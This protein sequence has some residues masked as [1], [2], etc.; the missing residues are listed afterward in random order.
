MFSRNS[1]IVVIMF[2]LV[3]QSL[4]QAGKITHLTH[5]LKLPVDWEGDMPEIDFVAESAGNNEWLLRVG[6]TNFEFT[7]KNTG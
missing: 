6:V 7:P 5:E 3:G 4:G 1:V 2:I